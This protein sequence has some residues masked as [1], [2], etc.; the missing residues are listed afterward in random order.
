AIFSYQVFHPFLN[1]MLWSLIL[2]VT[3]Y[4]L[5]TR[6]RPVL[7]S[8]G[9][10]AT[11]IVLISIV[12]M[13]APVY[14]LGTSLADSAQHAITALKSDEYHI[15]PPP[16]SVAGLPIIGNRLYDTWLQASSDLTALAR[17]F[18]PQ[19]KG[20]SVHLLGTIAG[21]G[22]AFLVFVAALIIAGVFMAFGESGHSN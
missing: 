21:V 12:T 6:L 3:L 8:N 9:R 16:E 18:A 14:F 1:L 11:V 10:T 7:G 17:K 13:L 19:L 2:A 22:I 20:A 15:P 5:H 4:P